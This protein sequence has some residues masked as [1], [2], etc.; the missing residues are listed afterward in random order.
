LPFERN[1]VVAVLGRRHRFAAILVRILRHRR[2][3]AP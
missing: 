3:A 1:A 2:S